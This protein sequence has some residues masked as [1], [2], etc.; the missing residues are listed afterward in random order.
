MK[1]SFAVTVIILFV[2]STPAFATDPTNSIYI[3]LTTNG[4][5]L[6]S[7]DKVKLPT[8]TMDDGLPGAQQDQIIAK[9]LGANPNAPALANFMAN[10]V[11]A[12]HVRVD[13]DIPNSTSHE[14]DLYFTAFGT[15]KAA[16]DGDFWKARMGPAGTMIFLAAK[17][18]QQ[19]SL[20]DI[21]EPKLKQRYA[22]A[23]V[24]LFGMV[25][26]SGTARAMEAIGEESVVI[27]FLM[28]PS[29]LNDKDFANE[30]RSVK[31][32]PAGA[33]IVGNPNPYDG[34]GAYSKITALKNTPGAL[35]VEYHII[36]D[37]PIGWFG[38]RPVM[39]SK[40]G[41]M[42]ENDVRSFRHDLKL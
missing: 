2:G 33:P 36:W 12:R 13:T 30:W 38:G 11:N 10:K 42:I 19:R 26:V 22:Y 41:T 31:F 18:L 27:A 16:A 6:A 9:L 1:S 23:N 21:D 4:V 25:K 40:L 20:K 34:V 28:D 7:G 39:K 15:L 17:D 8:C 35:F 5:P 37:E 32:G 29:F 3:D 24:D 14:L